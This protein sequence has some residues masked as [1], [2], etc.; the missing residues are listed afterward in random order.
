MANANWQT[1]SGAKILIDHLQ[2]GIYVVEGGKMVFANQRMADILECSISEIIGLSFIDL[3]HERDQP[4]VMERHR[5]RLAGENVPTLYNIHLK[6]QRGRIVSCSLN[7]SMR[8]NEAGQ[9]SI[10]G[11]AR[12]ITQQEMEIAELEASQMELKTIFD[13]LTD[14]YYRTNMQGIIT[15]ISPSCYD[16][17]GYRQEVM[18]GTPMSQYYKSPEERDKIVKAIIDGKGKA[19]RVEAALMRKDG[20]TAWIATNAVV[21]LDKNGNSMYI[22]GVTHDISD[23][24]RME[25]Q[26]L[27]LT[28]IDALTGAYNRRY[29]MDRCDELFR[30]SKR[31]QR[32]STIMMMDL[33]HFKKINDTY[34]HHI[35]DQALVA[36]TKACQKE[37]RDSDVL[38][39][40][41]G[42]EFGLMLPETGLQNAQALAERIRQGTADII[43]PVADNII[44]IT[45]SIGIAEI[46]ATDQAF[47]DT[48][49]R[50]DGAMYQSKEHGRNRVM[51]AYQ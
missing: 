5:A 2:D 38:G 31:Y 25:E 43:I 33:D 8:L 37:I 23:R 9:L 44:R 3:I 29:F 12:D 6:S 21:R 46:N 39:R 24:K 28:R 35:G 13:R 1:E 40:L 7:I 49:R 19:T 15:M 14:V 51:T 26:L 45:V 32:P 22:E 11:S 36:F 17:L 16:I 42:E 41:G 27:T 10:I 47:D 34:G 20:S 30:L 4:L 48:V 50:S 18:I